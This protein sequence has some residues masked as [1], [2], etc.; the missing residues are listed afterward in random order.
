MAK[1]AIFD[2]YLA[3]GS[4]TSGPSTVVNISMVDKVIALS[5]SVCLLLKPP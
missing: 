1:I 2:Q 4:T 3:F 5:S